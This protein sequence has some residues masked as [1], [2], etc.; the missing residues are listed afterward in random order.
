MCGKVGRTA[1]RSVTTDGNDSVNT[2]LAAGFNCL[3]HSL[4]GLEFGASVGIKHR[5]TLVDGV[6]HVTQAERLDISADKS[7]I[8]SVYTHYLN[9]VC[10]CGAD[11]RPDRRIHSGS[12]TAGGKYTYRPKF[13]QCYH[14][15]NWKKDFYY[16]MIVSLEYLF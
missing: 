11:N 6:R 8:S 1:K 14:L 7:R 12:I 15:V 3:F 16:N 4:F 13:F 9:T 2:E 5:S 10:D